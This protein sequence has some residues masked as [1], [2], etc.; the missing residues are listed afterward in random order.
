L[1]ASPSICSATG[2]ISPPNLPGSVAAGGR[3]HTT[4]FFG[5]SRISTRSVRRTSPTHAMRVGQG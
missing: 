2:I 4:D 5:S 1:A 3:M